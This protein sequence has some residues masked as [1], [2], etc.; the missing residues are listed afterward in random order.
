MGGEF[1]KELHALLTNPPTLKAYVANKVRPASPCFVY[2]T[3]CCG[4][5]CPLRGG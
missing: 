2:D 4:S 3:R 1:F 5:T